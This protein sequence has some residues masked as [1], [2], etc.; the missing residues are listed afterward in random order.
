MF[1]REELWGIRERANREASYDDIN[2][3]WKR[4]YTQLAIAV[5]HLDAMIAR[6]SISRPIEEG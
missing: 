5:D 1:A 4:A 6:S 3:D 2:V